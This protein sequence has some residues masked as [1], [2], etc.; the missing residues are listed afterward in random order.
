MRLPGAF[1][2]LPTPLPPRK[3][4]YSS[5]IDGGM[6]DCLTGSSSE[7]GSRWDIAAGLAAL[8]FMGMGKMLATLN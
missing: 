4:A 7:G 5:L 8:R 3:Q 1:L 2:F 6:Q